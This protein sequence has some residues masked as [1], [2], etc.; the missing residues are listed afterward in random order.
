MWAGAWSS[1]FPAVE[2]RPGPPDTKDQV[3]QHVMNARATGKPAAPLTCLVVR[4]PERRG[5]TPLSAGAPARAIGQGYPRLPSGA[6]AELGEHLAQM[7]LSRSG[8]NEKL[9]TDLRIRQTVT[10]KA[11]DLCFSCAQAIARL[12][13][14]S[15]YGGAC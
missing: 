12:G 2:V 4:G 7:P 6:D 10:G 11:R 14:P 1:R 3:G 8:T 15:L 13:A 9:R 5:A